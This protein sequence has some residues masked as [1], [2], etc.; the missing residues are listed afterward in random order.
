[1]RFV[2]ETEVSAA[3]NGRGWGGIARGNAVGWGAAPGHREGQ[4]Q[5]PH[6][7]LFYNDHIDV[8]LG[9]V[10]VRRGRRVVTPLLTAD[11]VHDHRVVGPG[12]GRQVWGPLPCAGQVAERDEVPGEQEEEHLHTGRGRCGHR[13]QKRRSGGDRGAKGEKAMV[14]SH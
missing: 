8:R 1:M 13:P 3:H 2:G 11:L 6:V 10:R 4:Q 7:L 14:A 9:A 12:L 5:G